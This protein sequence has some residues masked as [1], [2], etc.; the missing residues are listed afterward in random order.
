MS[1]SKYISKVP[2]TM[3]SAMEAFGKVGLIFTVEFIKR[4]TGE[5]RMMNCRFGVKSETEGSLGYDPFSKELFT[6]YDIQKL[7]YRHI[8]LEGIKHIKAQGIIYNVRKEKGIYYLCKC[9]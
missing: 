1:A 2:L 4:T 5:P 8:P 7:A 9:K 3:D 6:V